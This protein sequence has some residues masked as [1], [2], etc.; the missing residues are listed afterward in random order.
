MLD[1]R[2]SLIPV[3]PDEERKVNGW[4]HVET[5]ASQWRRDSAVGR[6]R[7]GLAAQGGRL[8]FGASE[9]QF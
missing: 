6:G 8:F 1:G 5:N 3:L 7:N 2:T 4:A 9:H